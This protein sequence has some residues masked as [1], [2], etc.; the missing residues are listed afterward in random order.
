VRRKTGPNNTRFSTERRGFD[1]DPT[2]PQEGRQRPDCR[3]CQL[4]SCWA[5]CRA[6]VSR[7]MLSPGREGAAVQDSASCVMDGPLRLGMP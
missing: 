1:K 5:G 3:L 6:G 2:G 7:V 4:R